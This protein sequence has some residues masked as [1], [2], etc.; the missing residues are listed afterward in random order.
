MENAHS[1]SSRGTVME[2]GLDG[3]IPVTVASGKRAEYRAESKV[4][5]PRAGV[6]AD[7]VCM[8]SLLARNH[9]KRLVVSGSAG[10]FEHHRESVDGALMTVSRKGGGESPQRVGGARGPRRVKS[11]ASHRGPVRALLRGVQRAGP[12]SPPADER[13]V[14]SWND[15]DMA[16]RSFECR[17]L[18]DMALRVDVNRYFVGTI[19]SRSRRR[20]SRSRRTCYR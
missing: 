16:D 14:G 18:Q 11:D 9:G 3:E 4:A 13:P 5:L 12:G 2:S 6:G 1:L 15:E 8:T 17:H 20:K 7:L 10:E 19:V